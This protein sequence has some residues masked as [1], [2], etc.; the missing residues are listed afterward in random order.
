MLE[1][2]YHSVEESTGSIAEPLLRPEID[3]SDLKY[4]TFDQLKAQMDHAI[5]ETTK[6]RNPYF[7]DFT[8]NKKNSMS[9]EFQLW[10]AREAAVS[11]ALRERLLICGNLRSAMRSREKL[12]QMKSQWTCRVPT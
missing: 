6:L 3:N 9:K 1:I 4:Q 7:Q 2:D 5:E 11:K 12:Y 8:V 10:N